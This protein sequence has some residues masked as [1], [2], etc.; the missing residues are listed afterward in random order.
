MAEDAPTDSPVCFFLGA[1]ASVPAGIPTT[2]GFVREYRAHLER[3]PQLLSAYL[4]FEALL[5]TWTTSGAT[6]KDPVDIEL[7]LEGLTLATNI[8]ANVAGAFFNARE[9]PA[10]A[11]PHLPDLLEDLREFIRERCSVDPER[12]TYWRQLLGFIQTYGR[13]HLFSAN[14]DL[15]METFL[16]TAGYP[17]TDGFDQSWNPDLFD[18]PTVQ[19]CL[20]KLH[21]SVN[22]YRTLN[23]AYFKLPIRN[24]PREVRTYSGAEAEA[25]MLYPAQKLEYSGPFLEMLG[26]LRDRL[27][28]SAVAVVIGYSFRDPHVARVFAEALSSNPNLVLIIVG[29]HAPEIYA[30]RLAGIRIDRL[31]VPPL[32]EV[33]EA[34]SLRGRVFA[35]PS[36]VENATGFLF[37]HTLPKLFDALGK[38]FEV[39][40]KDIRFEL[41]DYSEALS[42][43]LEAGFLDRCELI[44][45]RVEAFQWRQPRSPLE[46][47]GRKWAVAAAFRDLQSGESLWQSFLDQ[48][49][50]LATRY[51]W[52]QPAGQR[53]MGIRFVIGDSPGNG[54]VYEGS[55]VGRAWEECA[56]FAEQF[57]AYSGPG[58]RQSWIM[59]RARQLRNLSRYLDTMSMANGNTRAWLEQR[60][61]ECETLDPGVIRQFSAITERL[62]TGTE[63]EF[64]ATLPPIVLAAERS[65]LAELVV[66]LRSMKLERNPAH[67]VRQRNPFFE[68]RVG[69]KVPKE[70]R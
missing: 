42:K 52:V 30:T 49:E 41:V 10:L 56:E 16:Q 37:S 50:A 24:P 13:T 61:K 45:P 32:D 19:A 46:Y 40:E 48:L 47:A 39:R 29:P 53:N 70:L 9:S 4:K 11:D 31:G 66:R 25:L 36:T 68:H 58:K 57:A 26:R 67:P 65:L 17:Y 35:I 27:K 3:Q 51:L 18:S 44:E 8:H 55:D 2:V 22:W 64:A 34:S 38:E 15:V 43:H 28:S 20:Y 69:P 1:G 5:E 62:T 33:T 23:G 14:Y 21:G 63:S 60:M 7:L 6:P 59:E 54:S 12:I